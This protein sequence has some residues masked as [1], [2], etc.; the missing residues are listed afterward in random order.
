MDAPA[1]TESVGGGSTTIGELAARSSTERQLARQVVAL[2]MLNSISEALATLTDL[3]QALESVAETIT[4]MMN[5]LGVSIS[6]C[7]SQRSARRILAL[8]RTHGAPAALRDQLYPLQG[9]PL[10]ARLLNLAE[11]VLERVTPDQQLPEFAGGAH[12][13][14]VIIAPLWRQGEICGML[15]VAAAGRENAFDDAD[16]QL[17][18]NT[19]RQVAAAI[20]NARLYQNELRRRQMAESLRVTAAAVTRSLDQATVLSTIM[21][22]LPDL[23]AC[24]SAGL[25]LHDGDALELVTASG[26]VQARVGLRIPLTSTNPAVR[27]FKERCTIII[28]DLLQEPDFAQWNASPIIRSWIGTPLMIGDLPIGM[29]GVDSYA[30]GAYGE[31]DLHMLEVFASQVAVAIENTRLFEQAR[32]A[33]FAAEAASRAKSDFLSNMSHELRTPLNGILGYAHALQRHAGLTTAQVEGLTIIQRSGEHLLALLNSILDMAKIEANRLDLA[34]SMFNLRDFL[35]VLVG[36]MRLQAE[37]R[38]LRI[39]FTHAGQLPA[40][41]RAD[42]QRLRQV[43][44]NLLGNAVKFTERGSVGLHVAALD[45]APGGAEQ[46]LRFEVTDTGPGIEPSEHA[47]IFEPFEQAGPSAGRSEG[48]GLGLPISRRLLQLMGSELYLISAPGAG[49]TFWFELNLPV[50]SG[51]DAQ[52]PRIAGYHGPRLTLLAVDDQAVNCAVLR[53]MLAPLGFTV[54]IATSG[55]QALE[56]A[57]AVRPAAVLTDLVMPDMSG[58]ELMRSIRNRPAL[59]QCALIAVTARHADRELLLRVG[60]AEL[61]AKPLSERTL[62]GALGRALGLQWVTAENG[63]RAQARQAA[64]VVPPADTL[65]ALLHLAR[66]GD[67]FQLAELAESLAAEP[68]YWPFADQVRWLAREF[69]DT[70]LLEL[71]QEAA[72]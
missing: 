51:N 39:T 2:A 50:S 23:I 54:L 34:P 68:A 63:V 6:T 1:L 49:S 62:L 55:A 47:R 37:E 3:D 41:V 36:I 8:Y 30:V 64:Y 25:S 13:D 28:D 4:Q 60:C 5:A 40:F 31:D 43:L 20:D 48:V 71:L 18:A 70:E 61:I 7:N 29:L 52:P 22:Q 14:Q 27:V 12:P 17:V 10:T 11:P 42:E 56:L 33:W 16:V 32:L 35:D 53:N 45:A 59:E 15:A 9:H 65:A 67:L 19:A 26:P 38:G 72:E 66:R 69:R 24:Q 44:L 46:T 21:A 58:L 57:E